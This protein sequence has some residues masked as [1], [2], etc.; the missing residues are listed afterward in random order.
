MQIKQMTEAA[1]AVFMQSSEFLWLESTSVVLSSANPAF[2]LHQ[3]ATAALLEAVCAKA[4]SLDA[5]TTKLAQLA[6]DLA[7]KNLTPEFLFDDDT[8]AHAFKRKVAVSIQD[9]VM[10][11]Y[12]RR[13]RKRDVGCA[14]F[15]VLVR[16]N[17]EEA[18][19]I[20][21]S[22]SDFR[23]FPNND[24]TTRIEAVDKKWH[25][26]A[27]GTSLFKLTEVAVQFLMLADPFVRCNMG[28]DPSGTTIR[29]RVD[30]DA[31]KW[32]REFMLKMGFEEGDAGTEDVEFCKTV[33]CGLY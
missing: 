2:F 4:E 30:L 10:S 32:Q 12:G 26:N 33:V 29:S 20:A 16:S 15:A 22:L 24:F 5:F 1:I 23:P 17:E 6:A 27:V 3:A 13:L 14:Y 31:P 25:R 18:K 7:G 19:V 28:K 21:S 9:C 8:G 11:A